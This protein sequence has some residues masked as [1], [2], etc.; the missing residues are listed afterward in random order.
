MRELWRRGCVEPGRTGGVG[1][2]ARAL[3][4][5]VREFCQGASG[6]VGYALG[7]LGLGLDLGLLIVEVV[8]SATTAGGVGWNESL[9][10]RRHRSGRDGDR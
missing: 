6:R 5:F 9:G 3:K 7:L 2:K 10:E 4:R 1:G 8:L